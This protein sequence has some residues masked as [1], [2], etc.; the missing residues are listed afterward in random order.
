MGVERSPQDDEMVHMCWYF[1]ERHS[2]SSPWILSGQRA[3]FPMGLR[4]MP[5][6]VL[7]L[8]GNDGE[9]NWILHHSW[10]SI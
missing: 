10:L 8:K 6:T 1:S 4:M 2:E 7:S 5:E 3:V 9:P